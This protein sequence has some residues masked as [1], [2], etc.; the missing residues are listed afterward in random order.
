MDIHHLPDL[1]TILGF[2]LSQL[3]LWSIGL[4]ARWGDPDLQPTCLA[5]VRPWLL[6]LLIQSYHRAEKYQEMLQ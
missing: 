6:Q 3:A 4:L 1:P 2:P 5:L